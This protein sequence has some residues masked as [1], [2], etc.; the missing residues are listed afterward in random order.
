MPIAKITTPG[1]IAIGF[2]VVLLWAC[3]LGERITLRRVYA[4]RAAVMRSLPH[5]GARRAEPVG[6]R[7][8]AGR[9]RRRFL[10][11]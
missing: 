10:A 8:P 11:S 5:P 1:L 3:V 2:A 7:A 4:E 6:D 9:V